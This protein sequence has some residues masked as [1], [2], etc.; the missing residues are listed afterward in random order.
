MHMYVSDEL[1]LIYILKFALDIRPVKVIKN[2]INPAVSVCLMMQSFKSGGCWW[3]SEDNAGVEEQENI[4]TA[5]G[6]HCRTKSCP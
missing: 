1:T 3:C 6:Y 4:C 2:P 5:L